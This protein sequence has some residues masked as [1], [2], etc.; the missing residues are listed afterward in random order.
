MEGEKKEEWKGNKK[1]RSKSCGRPKSHG[2][3]KEKCWNFGKVGKFK[4]DCKEERKKN[5]KEK[6]D[7]KDESKKYSQEDRGDYF[8][9]FLATHVGQDAW[10]SFL[11]YDF[12]LGLV[13]SEWVIWLRKYIPQWKLSS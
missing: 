2:K 8:V 6:N 13:F 1:G 12:L 10:F 11:P 9:A 7:C 5:K 3:S 4:R